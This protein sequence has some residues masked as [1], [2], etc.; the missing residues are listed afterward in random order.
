MWSTQTST[1]RLFT[2]N[3][4]GSTERH[5]IYNY[6]YVLCG[7]VTHQLYLTIWLHFLAFSIAI[8]SYITFNLDYTPLQLRL[9]YIF[10]R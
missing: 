6:S 9:H 1:Y 4:H 2:S 7:V 10:T 8:F 5:C 3:L